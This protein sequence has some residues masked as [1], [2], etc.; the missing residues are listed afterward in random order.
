L[1][2]HLLPGCKGGNRKQN[3]GEESKRKSREPKTEAPPPLTAAQT[4][5]PILAAAFTGLTA[6]GGPGTLVGLDPDV[7]DDACHLG[8]GVHY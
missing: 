4:A 3:K 8:L 7:A 6:W 1:D 2:L 5:P